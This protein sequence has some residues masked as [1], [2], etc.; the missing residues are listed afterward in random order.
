MAWSGW[1]RSIG[2]LSEPQLSQW[3]LAPEC[4]TNVL[5]EKLERTK[6]RPSKMKTKT[7]TKRLREPLVVDG[8]GSSSISWLRPMYSTQRPQLMRFAPWPSTQDLKMSSPVPLSHCQAARRY[9]APRRPTRSQR[10]TAPLRLSRAR[11]DDGRW[12]A[13]PSRH[14]L[15]WPRSR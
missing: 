9:A 5:F 11:L 13:R 4:S 3:S 14:G 7:K 8:L 2:R 6:M 12:S 10:Q 1:G 15:A